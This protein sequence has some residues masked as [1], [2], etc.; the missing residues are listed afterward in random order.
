MVSGPAWD[1]I[2]STIDRCQIT[3][4][5]IT[6]SP[7][8]K[9]SASDADEQRAEERVVR[10]ANGTDGELDAT[11]GELQS[12]SNGSQQDNGEKETSRR[13]HLETS[14]SEDARRSNTAMSGLILPRFVY[15]SCRP[16]YSRG[17]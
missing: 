13:F 12:S 5:A 4:H 8:Q 11:H 2:Q 15:R 10:D 1:R 6:K 14:G 3:A 7:P 9:Y 16:L 17:S